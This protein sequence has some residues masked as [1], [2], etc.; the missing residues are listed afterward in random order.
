MGSPSLKPPLVPKAAAA[1]LS[2]SGQQSS[3]AAL[4][5]PSG[6]QS[7]SLLSPKST[8]PLQLQPTTPAVDRSSPGQKPSATTAPS[9]QQQQQQ[10]VTPSL[11]SPSQQRSVLVSPRPSEALGATPLVSAP[12]PPNE[13]QQ[14]LQQDRVVV[15]PHNPLRSPQKPFSPPKLSA[16][17][18]SP[19]K[20]TPPPLSSP[21][22]APTTIGSPPGGAAP[23]G[24]LS[25]PL[26]N[27]LSP[28]QQPINLDVYLYPGRINSPEFDQVPVSP[29]PPPVLSP[30]G[31]VDT[32]LYT[33]SPPQGGGGGG[34][35]T[36]DL[37]GSPT[38]PIHSAF[39]SPTVLSP[40]RGVLSPL[41]EVDLD[42]YSL[43]PVQP[44]V[45]PDDP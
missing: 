39:G 16:Q 36:P 34:V 11:L 45:A 1:L 43:S 29:P 24:T 9:P 17:S 22:A 10:P 37:V 27:P 40:S 32:G 4:L 23:Q 42:N 31:N 13:P 35:A 15:S 19:S 28:G 38:P 6:Q 3:T 25:P 18:L 8:A 7:S 26:A 30:S 33:L 21:T 5:S 44:P 20:A 12:L 41:G 14:Q 2:P